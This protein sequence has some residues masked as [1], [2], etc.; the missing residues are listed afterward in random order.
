MKPYIFLLFSSLFLM[1]VSKTIERVS[2]DTPVI[3][4]PDAVSVCPT[5][6]TCCISVDGDYSCCPL[7]DGVCCSDRI[8]CCPE[9]YKCDLKIFKCDRTVGATP[10][11]MVASLKKHWKIV[12]HIV[13]RKRISHI[14]IWIKN[15]E[16]RNVL[17]VPGGE[18][19]VC[20]QCVDVK[21]AIDRKED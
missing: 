17:F 16:A 1:V 6:S 8:H 18:C 12:V 5:T 15:R 13:D 4:C 14:F 11:A 21:D 2:T 10:L 3:V 7:T 19:D 9:H 20:A